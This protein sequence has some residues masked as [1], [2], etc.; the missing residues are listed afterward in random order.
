[1]K[2]HVI[3][4]CGLESRK[5]I[6]SLRKRKKQKQKQNKKQKENDYCKNVS[7]R[8][9]FFSISISTSRILN[10][11]RRTPSDRIESSRLLLDKIKQI[12]VLND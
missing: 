11:T 3:V 6:S 5:T 4:T 12:K 10:R 7:W 1:M 9:F 8:I 2:G